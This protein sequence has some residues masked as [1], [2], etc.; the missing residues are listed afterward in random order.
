MEQHN[1][2]IAQYT[3]QIE[4]MVSELGQNANLELQALQASI[5]QLNERLQH[6]NAINIAQLEQSVN[7]L[8]QRCVVGEGKINELQNQ[9]AANES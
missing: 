8:N 1:I 3:Q 9:M 6:L 7:E 4:Q 5:H 2:A